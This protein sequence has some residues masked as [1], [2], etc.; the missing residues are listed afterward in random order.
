M[1]ADYAGGIMLQANTLTQAES[2]LHSLEQAAGGIG[3]HMSADKIEYMCFN[4]K[5]DISTQNGGSLKLVNKFTYLG[6]WTLSTEND[7]NLGLAKAW[8]V[9]KRLSIIW[10]L[11]LPEQIKCYFFQSAAVLILLHGCTT[12]PLTKCIEKKLDRNYTRMLWAILNKSWKQYPIKWQLY[13]HQP[14][15]SQTI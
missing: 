8:T 6:N 13:S 5:G 11:N 14:L 3:L 10:K 4:Q 7:I 15:I 1:D 2:L 12:W 9:I